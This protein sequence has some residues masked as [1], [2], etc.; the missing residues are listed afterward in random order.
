MEQVQEIMQVLESSARIAAATAYEVRPPESLKQRAATLFDD[1]RTAIATA[2]QDL[3]ADDGDI[4]VILTDYRAALGGNYAFKATQAQMQ[5]VLDLRPRRAYDLGRFEVYAPL[6]AQYSQQVASWNLYTAMMRHD[7]TSFESNES[8]KFYLT[9]EPDAFQICYIARWI[10]EPGRILPEDFDGVTPGELKHT[11]TIASDTLAAL[12]YFTYVLVAKYGLNATR[13]ELEEVNA[14]DLNAF[15]LEASPLDWAMAQADGIAAKMEEYDYYFRTLPKKAQ[16]QAATPVVPKPP[17]RRAAKPLDFSRWASLAISRDV[18]NSAAQGPW[19]LSP[20]TQTDETGR[21]RTV[22]EMQEPGMRVM[23]YTEERAER[24]VKALEYLTQWGEWNG[25]KLAESGLQ[26]VTATTI[27]QTLKAL[28]LL[29]NRDICQCLGGYVAAKD[30]VFENI[31][32]SRFTELATGQADAKQAVKT[33]ILNTLKGFSNAWWLVVRTEREEHKKVRTKLGERLKY[34]RAFTLR[35]YGTDGGMDLRIA[36]ELQ[37]ESYILVRGIVLNKMQA[38]AKGSPAKLRFNA[39]LLT[40]GNCAEGDLQD[41]VFGYT[42]DLDKLLR[43]E[44]KLRKAAESALAALP[45]LEKKCKGSKWMKEANVLHVLQEHYDR[46]EAYKAAHPDAEETDKVRRTR[47]ARDAYEALCTYQ[48]TTLKE[49]KEKPNKRRDRATLAQWFEEYEKDGILTSQWRDPGKKKGPV[50]Y[51]TI[52]RPK[53][54]PDEQ[55]QPKDA[56]RALTS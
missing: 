30:F 54:K 43:K 27:G 2:L 29:M 51:W 19:M 25:E 56:A 55:E 36:T 52:D 17:K 49:A 13:E 45:D 9:S 15:E 37:G 41:Y 1:R 21:E 39:Q 47:A 24:T 14:P 5:K 16:T 7:N 32:L 38:L 10:T 8:K 46:W 48:E 11:L 42:Y 6:Y 22:E 3:G 33:G 44:S 20:R 40:K 31:S 35:S 34:V 18:M 53:K 23:D 28:A 4:S 12:D 50:W 26:G